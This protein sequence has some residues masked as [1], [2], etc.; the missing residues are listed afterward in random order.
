MALTTEQVNAIW[1]QLEECYPSFG[2]NPVWPVIYPVYLVRSD[3]QLQTQLA[4]SPEEDYWGTSVNFLLLVLAAEG[5]EL[6]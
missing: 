2:L 5:E 4:G 6:L 1:D 3:I